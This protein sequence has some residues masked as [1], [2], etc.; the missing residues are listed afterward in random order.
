MYV[1]DVV[2]QVMAC[3]HQVIVVVCVDVVDVVFDTDCTG[4]TL[5]SVVVTVVLLVLCGV[6]L[7]VLCGVVVEV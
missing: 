2:V 6:V 4:K 1:V 3:V 7:F 5:N